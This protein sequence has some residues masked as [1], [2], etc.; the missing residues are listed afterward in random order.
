ML[1]LTIFDIAKI[2]K[3]DPQLQDSL[4]KNYINYDN[5]LKCEISDSL[6]SSF[7]ELH[8][9]LSDLQYKQFMNE[10]VAGKRE[11]T[12]DLYYQAKKQAMEN[13]EDMLAGKDI[14]TKQIEEIR[15]KLKS[16]TSLPQPQAA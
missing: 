2:L 11:L 9:K 8:D 12:S 14:E 6:W 15:N 5:E 16:F 3:L 7:F 13:I 1:K 4:K 10:V